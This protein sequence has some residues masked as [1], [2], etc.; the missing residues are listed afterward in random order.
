MSAPPQYVDSPR[1]ALRVF[2]YSPPQGPPG[3][4]ITANID[5]TVQ[6][7][8][9]IYLRLVL[10]RRALT[11]SVRRLPYKHFELQARVPMD[12]STGSPGSVMALSAQALGSNDELIDTVTFGNFTIVDFGTYVA[13]IT[14]YTAQDD[15]LDSSIPPIVRATERRDHRESSSME[16]YPSDHY[17]QDYSCIRTVRPSKKTS[18]IRT[19]RTVSGDDDSGTKCAS[20]VLEAD[21]DDMSKGWEKGELAAGRRLVCFSRVQEGSTLRVSCAAIKQEDYAEGDAVV[22]C[23]YRKDTDSC[24]VTSVDIILLLERLVGQEFDIEEKNRIRRNLEG[25]RPKTISKNRPE[26]SEFFLQIMNFPAPSRAI[27]RRT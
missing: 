15:T 23:I 1:G 21:L 20:L 18:L 16:I 17:M 2:A 4:T 12:D 22:S 27:L 11:T 5:F 14:G 26:S 3:A 6:A 10:G 19:R 13:P 9:T 7:T 24:Y 8:D 25:F